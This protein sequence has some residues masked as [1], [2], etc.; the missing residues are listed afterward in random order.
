MTSRKTKTTE[1]KHT[2]ALLHKMWQCDVTEFSAEF[3]AECSL[4]TVS[5]MIQYL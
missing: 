3:S 5:R 4:D 2:L 1:N